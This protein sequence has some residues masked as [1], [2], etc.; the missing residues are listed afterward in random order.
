VAATPSLATIAKPTITE[1]SELLALGK[2]LSP[3]LD[4]LRMAL[5]KKRR[6]PRRR[7]SALRPAFPR[8]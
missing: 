2:R 7:T 4:A 5:V 1:S 3:L 8:A 6:R